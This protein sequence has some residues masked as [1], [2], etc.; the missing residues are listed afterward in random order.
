MY[1]ERAV[2]CYSSN[3]F[4]LTNLLACSISRACDIHC[5]TGITPYTV[6][7]SWHKAE[8][9]LLEVLNEWLCDVADVELFP[10]VRV[11][12]ISRKAFRISV[13]GSHFKLLF[14]IFIRL[15]T[16]YPGGYPTGK[17]DS[18]NLLCIFCH[19]WPLLCW[20]YFAIRVVST[21]VHI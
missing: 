13:S 5:G 20:D 11:L 4:M 19:Q 15:Q 16:H 7:E 6:L 1:T 2:S 12:E 9:I 3:R 14:D 21:F 10:R 8:K 18:D 17:R